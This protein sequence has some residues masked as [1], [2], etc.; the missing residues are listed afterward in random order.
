MSI[1]GAVTS[2]L[3]LASYGFNEVLYVEGQRVASDKYVTGLDV[4]IRH[5]YLEKLK[6]IK[7]LPV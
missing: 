1:F 4:P 5:R 7:L 3:Y 2:L 6:K